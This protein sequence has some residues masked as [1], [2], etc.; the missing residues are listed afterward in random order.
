[1]EKKH[2]KDHEAVQPRPVRAPAQPR[3]APRVQPVLTEK[4]RAILDD[5]ENIIWNPDRL[6]KLQG[7]G[8][9][10]KQDK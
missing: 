10:K 6:K 2:K 4:D 7:D 3:P 5:V 8:K 1:M 9:A